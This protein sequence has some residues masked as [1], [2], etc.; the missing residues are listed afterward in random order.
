M[1][2]KNILAALYIQ[3]RIQ[4]LHIAKHHNQF[5]NSYIYAWYKGV[6]P[7]LSDTDN[8][9]PAMP[10]EPYSEFFNVSREKGEVLLKRLD[11]ADLS[12]EYLTFYQ[13]ED[14]F[15]TRGRS[16]WDRTDLLHLCRYFYLDN[17]FSAEL[18]KK[19]ATPSE[20]PTEAYSITRE[21]ERTEDIYFM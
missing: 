2:E 13:L 4:I 11:D 7:F 19:L 8:S 3:Q 20:C 9:V 6:C 16:E 14:E 17:R 12:K 21:F 10:H 15:N 18:W 5:T 1:D